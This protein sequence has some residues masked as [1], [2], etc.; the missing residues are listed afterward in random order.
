MSC[1]QFGWCDDERCTCHHDIANQNYSPEFNLIDT[2]K[3]I[4][5]HESDYIFDLQWDEMEFNDYEDHYFEPTYDDEY[6]N[7]E[8]YGDI[9]GNENTE[10]T[11]SQVSE[12][13]VA[14]TEDETNDNACLLDGITNK[15][16]YL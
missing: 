5:K 4:K 6:L 12:E 16:M 14:N 8:E 10:N 9:K 7:S 13:D 2:I 3:A 15:F 1:K 11:C